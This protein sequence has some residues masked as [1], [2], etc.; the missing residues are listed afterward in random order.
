MRGA[1]GI[2]PSPLHELVPAA[3]RGLLPGLAYQLG[4][5]LA[6]PTSPI[7]FALRDRLGY[8]RALAGF[9]VVTIVVLAIVV[10]GGDRVKRG[11]RTS[12]DATRC[13]AGGGRIL[14][15]D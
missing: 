3:V 11:A 15:G 14:R 8:S 6:A 7:E 5:P 1:W 9:E 2:V 10:R 13:T 12:N 4:I